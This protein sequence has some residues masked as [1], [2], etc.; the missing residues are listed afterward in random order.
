MDLFGKK[1]IAQMQSENKAL[2]EEVRS[3][4]SAVSATVQELS[5]NQNRGS[6]NRYDANPYKEYAS[7]ITAIDQKY[8]AE[9][10]WGNQQVGS[11]IDVRSAFI[12]GDGLTLKA[13]GDVDQA[14][15]EMDFAR[16]F[17]KWNNLEF[18]GLQE[19]A[20]E[21][22]IEGKI[23]L[24]LFPVAL[25]EPITGE[26]GTT[27]TKM[28]AARFVPWQQ[29]K[30]NVVTD[31]KD[32]M[33]YTGVTGKEPVTNA[34]FV[35]SEGE[36]VYLK[37]GGRIAEPNRAT[38]KI[39]KCLTQIDYLDKALRDWREIN[40]LFAAPTPTMECA[41]PQDADAMATRFTKQ[42]WKAG[43]FLIHVGQFK[44]AG[45]PMDGIQSLRE[46]ITANAKL[47]SGTTGVPVHFLGF[48]ELMSNRATADNLFELITASTQK[49]REGWKGLLNELLDNAIAMH[50]VE[51]QT[52]GLQKGLIEVSIPFISKEQ[53]DRFT[54][55]YL[56]AYN[57]SLITKRTALTF[58]PGVD[59]DDEMNQF[60][61]EEQDK[62]DEAKDNPIFAPE[63]TDQKPNMPNMNGGQ[64]G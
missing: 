23:L 21:G 58:L 5:I 45:A 4:D 24:R 26:N 42:N 18:E 48:P 12:V 7:Q 6:T 62:I 64:N 38:P 25:K 51:A 39:A 19:L 20:K 34:D 63:P 8:K 56:A 1:M 46:E 47:I 13:R 40:N 28:I 36:F 57:A 43:K 16:E 2:R 37:F 11:I 32:Y 33:Y 35:L 54:T 55:V 52:P 9:A 60:D 14:K 59:A 53:Y 50:N 41:T 30:Y 61:I 17:F 31:P 27:F 44:F 29:Y 49:E 3:L 22:E 10:D 15:K